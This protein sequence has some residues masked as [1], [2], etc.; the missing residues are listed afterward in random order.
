[1]SGRFEGESVR[2]LADV[3][4]R[5]P[6]LKYVILEE[7]SINKAFITKEMRRYK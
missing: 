5:M 6:R 1:M 7:K 2:C 4:V 3:E